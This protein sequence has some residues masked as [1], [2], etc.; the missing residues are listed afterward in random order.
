MLQV[1]E[2]MVSPPIFV[3]R[4]TPLWRAARAMKEND[5]SFL[6]VVQNGI[7]LGVITAK[8]LARATALDGRSPIS[9]TA[10]EIM[11]SPA[12]G[13]CGDAEIDDAIVMMRE[14]NV[15]RLVVTD[16]RGIL[17]GVVSL[18]GLAGKLPDESIARALERHAENSGPGISPAHSNWLSALQTA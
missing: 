9:T 11:S 4:E 3:Q 8:D 7:A 10:G 14:R 15:H 18:A 17:R 13:L 2:V 16:A 5:C 6:P 1:N 12:F